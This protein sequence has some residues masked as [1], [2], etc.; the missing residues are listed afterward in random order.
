MSALNRIQQG[1]RALLAFTQTVDYELT[2]RYLTTEQMALFRRMAKSEQ[3]HSLNVLR[4]VLAQEEQTPH[5]LADRK[6]VV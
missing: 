5:D 6:S 1:I 4:D 2:E 3:L